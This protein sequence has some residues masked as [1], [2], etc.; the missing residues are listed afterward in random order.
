MVRNWVYHPPTGTLLVYII[1]RFR[2]KKREKKE[3]EAR[4][5]CNRNCVAA[6]KEF[7]TKSTKIPKSVR[8]KG[9]RKDEP[10]STVA[11]VEEWRK[12][13]NKMYSYK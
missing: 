8:A 7:I 4:K 6:L 12:F 10:E 9:I 13:Q 5:L 1:L 11:K 3:K 2:A